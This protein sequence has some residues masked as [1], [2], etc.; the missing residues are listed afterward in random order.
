MYRVKTNSREVHMTNTS[1][2]LGTDGIKLRC[3]YT[4]DPADQVTGVNFLV[5][6]DATDTFVNI[7]ESSV[8]TSQPKLLPTG[9]YLFGSAYIT[10]LSDLQSEVVLIFNDLK[11]QLSVHQAAQTDSV[12]MQIFVRDR[13]Q[14]PTVTKHP[15]KQKYIVGRDLSIIL[16]CTSDVNHKPIYRWYKENHDK[17]ISTDGNFTIKN[18]AKSTTSRTTCSNKTAELK[19]DN[20]AVVVVGTVC[21]SIILVLCVMLFAVIQNN[22]KTVRCPL[23]VNCRNITEVYVNTTQQ[24][25]SHYE[26]VGH[27]FRCS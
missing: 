11:C 16:T 1:E 4:K 12:P 14:I 19:N 3:L 24:H 2:V 5:K 10:K 23:T 22:K 6:S 26:G 15:D 7:A 20:T 17:G 9:V 27:A 13:V 25:N 8:F 18:K 21:G